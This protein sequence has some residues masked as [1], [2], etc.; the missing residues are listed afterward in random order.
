M[1]TPR[2]RAPRY[3]RSAAEWRSWLVA[4]H[5]TARE[6][7][8]GFHKVGTGKPSLT[9][10]ESVDEALCYGWIDG[11][12][13]RVDDARYCIRFSPRRARSTWSAVNIRRFGELEA[14]GRVHETGRAAFARRKENRRGEYSYEQR[15]DTWDEPYRS[16]FARHRAAFRFFQSQPAGY[17]KVVIWWVVSAKRESTRE[18]RL[19]QLIADSARGVRLQQLDQ[20]AGGTKRSK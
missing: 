19:A 10:P 6:I 3:F 16:R 1:P 12:R 20:F 14:A 17:R 18:K 15:K 8:V 11:V 13:K 4:N 9:W 7:V 5:A 2:P